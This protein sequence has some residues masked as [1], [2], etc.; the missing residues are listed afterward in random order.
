LGKNKAHNLAQLDILQEE[1]YVNWVRIIFCAAVDLILDK[2]VFR[3]HL[4]VGVIGIY[5]D[6]PAKGDG[7]GPVAGEECPPDSFPEALVRSAELR[8]FHTVDI[9][10]QKALH[11][12]ELESAQT[13]GACRIPEPR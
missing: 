6:G 13:F 7:N 9:I 4:D 1:L 2:I 11:G 5:I 3:E 8:R 12:E 10:G